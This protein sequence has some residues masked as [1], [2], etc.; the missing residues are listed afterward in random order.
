MSRT[1]TANFYLGLALFACWAPPAQGQ[2]P[3]PP[4]VFVAPDDPTPFQRSDDI[5]L[6]R[7]RPDPRPIQ[8]V[9][10]VDRTSS[11]SRGQVEQNQI[12]RE[13]DE[14]GVP[15]VGSP[16]ILDQFRRQ[17]ELQRTEARIR[18][19]RAVDPNSPEARD[20]ERELEARRN[21]NDQTP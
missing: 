20:L 17:R 16:G 6:Y 3:R 21:E 9:E 18:E 19:L 14:A 15:A 13:L 10:P 4:T 11:T 1:A 5:R 8:R 12:R 2:W 7:N